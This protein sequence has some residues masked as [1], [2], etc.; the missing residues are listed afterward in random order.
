MPALRQ[1]QRRVACALMA[2]MCSFQL[3][4][5]APPSTAKP[6]GSA[7]SIASRRSWQILLQKSAIRRLAPEVSSQA[8]GTEPVQPTDAPGV[9]QGK[10]VSGTAGAADQD[11]TIPLRCELACT[12]VAKTSLPARLPPGTAPTHVP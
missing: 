8:C 1:A 10:V 7:A 9:A 3:I 6:I 2:S 4:A 5:K 11:T 12:A